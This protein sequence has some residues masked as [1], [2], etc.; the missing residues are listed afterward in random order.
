MWWMSFPDSSSEYGQ[1]ICLRLLKRNRIS[2]K[3]SIPPGRSSP[4]RPHTLNDFQEPRAQGLAAEQEASLSPLT[5]QAGIKSHLGL[6]LLILPQYHQEKKEGRDSDIYEGI[7]DTRQ[8]PQLFEKTWIQQFW[9]ENAQV[10]MCHPWKSQL[11][12][13][14]LNV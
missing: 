11:T 12:L 8:E 14:L 7:L 9:E 3:N 5:N 4:K 2:W 10:G 13:S 6:H 1:F